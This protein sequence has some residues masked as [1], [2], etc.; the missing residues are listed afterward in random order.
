M[1]GD[2]LDEADEMELASGGP[3]LD[4]F[5]IT[6][7]A[8]EA[9]GADGRLAPPKQAGWPIFP[10]DTEGLRMQELRDPELPEPPR[11]GEDGPEHCSTCTRGRGDIVW[12]DDRW[13][14]SMAPE[15][16]SV[17]GVTL[18]P[19]AHLDFHDLTD[20][21]GAELGVVMVRAQRALAS[22]EGVGR[23]HVYKWGDG[24]A[25]LHIFLVARPAGM[26]Q[27]KGMYLSTWMF[28]LPPLPA[29]EWEAIRV[30]V[31]AALA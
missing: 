22:I 27:L 14:V 18:H 3:R 9:S 29:D 16:Q 23:V 10:F 7:R 1:S 2:E 8:R 11:N 12:Q 24:G 25:H 21:Q 20:E 17:P 28:A 13:M 6:L 15:P 26:L 4:G 31:A 30:Q 5:D 19:L